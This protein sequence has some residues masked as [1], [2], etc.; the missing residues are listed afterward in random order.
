MQQLLDKPFETPLPKNSSALNQL[1]LSE[2]S[3]LIA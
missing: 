2:D 3:S 1:E